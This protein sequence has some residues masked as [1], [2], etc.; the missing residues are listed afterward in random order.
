MKKLLC[1]LFV[2]SFTLS[3][4]QINP[5]SERSKLPQTGNAPTV[6]AFTVNG[7]TAAD[8]VL[9]IQP[10]SFGTVRTQPD[11]PLKYR[12]KRNSTGQIIWQKVY[13]VKS[14][15]GGVII[16]GA[17][18][19]LNTVVNESKLDFQFGELGDFTSLGSTTDE[20]GMA[21]VRLQQTH[22]GIPVYGGEWIYHLVNNEVVLGNGRVYEN[23]KTTTTANLNS[24]KAAQIGLAE[25]LSDHPKRESVYEFP[26]PQL[27][28]RV[29]EEGLATLVYRMEVRP[30][31][32]H[33]YDV[34][35]DAITGAILEKTD[36][37]CSIG[38]TAQ[39]KDLSGTT[40]TI[41]TY[42]AGGTY[43][44][45]DAS[46]DMFKS[47][48]SIPSKV[49]GGIQ[50]LDARNTSASTVY[51]ITNSS[52]SW[53]DASAVSAHYNAGLSYEYF[54]STHGR[55]SINGSG[56]TIVSVVNVT[57]DDG[58]GLDN[59]YW[60]GRWMFYGNGRN[61]FEPL[62]GGLD[63]A[64]HEL[65]HGVISNTANLEYKNQSGAINE[66]FADI[67]GVMID[68]DDWTLGEDIVKKNVYTSGAMR[69]L[70][71]PH[72]GGN[73]LG[74]RGYQPKRMSEFYTG[75]AD[76]GGVHINSGIPNHAFYLFA[77][78]V[79]KDKA[80]KV[81][82][83]ALS[84][85]LTTK[86]QF[87]DL[88]YAVER[89]ATDLYGS[90][91]LSEV[92]KAF[93]QVEIYDP[94]NN[95]SGNGDEPDDLSVNPGTQY[96]VSAD[97][98]SADENTLYRS[99]TVGEDFLA[100][101]KTVPARKASITDDGSEII[102]VS[103]S[104]ELYRITIGSSVTQTKISN[105]LWANA[106]ISKD[107]NMLAAVSTVKDSAIYVYH[108]EKEEWRE[109]RLYNPTYTEGVDAGGV[110]RAD[111]IE[112]DPSG[113]Y[114]LYDAESVIENQ[115]GSDYS[116][117]D[118]GLLHVWDLEK[119]DWSGGKIEKVFTQ[120][121]EGVSIGNASFAKNSPHIIAYDYIDVNSGQSSVVTRNLVTNASSTIYTGS[122]LGFPSYSIK[123]DQMIFDAFNTLNEE[124]VGIVD[125][126]ADKLT[127]DGSATV[128]I[129]DAKWAS[130]YATGTRA[131]LS[132]KKEITSFSFPGLS[133]SPEGKIEGTTIS[134][135][136]QAGS[137]LTEMIPTF[138]HSVNSKVF[139][140]GT[141]QISGVSKV[142]FS[143]QVTYT[144]RAQDGTTQDYQVNATQLAD[145][146]QLAK[147]HWNAYP[148]PFTERIEIQLVQPGNI[149]LTNA[150]GKVVYQR[151]L[152]EGH[153]V[154]DWSDLPSGTYFLKESSGNRRKV[155]RLV[156]L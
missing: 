36:L 56:G 103:S 32:L 8:E 124:V 156:K 109:F 152:T 11:K 153:H 107:G 149:Q 20:L 121:P 133:G 53:N 34:W 29:N 68:R 94:N 62:A 145:V 126:Q 13:P 136:L 135:T 39:A 12:Y 26:T 16:G 129:E 18:L 14:N 2:C 140:N 106:A 79:G 15:P 154:L 97:V 99:N 58:S 41:N 67:F 71:N 28:I 27:M 132:D 49:V 59:A 144:V 113:Q 66:S 31:V 105:D 111:A 7:R 128:L 139:I 72:N 44:L 45:V 75:S 93:D 25:V 141:E 92:K 114:I 96:I 78:A 100:I 89:S 54:K 134:I 120:L 60:N 104:N 70:S 146:Q 150:F 38:A 115:G 9:P 52:N 123:D 125:L 110:L 22:N 138:T 61:A 76:N 130:W 117:W 80:E 47:S 88:R 3:F 91:E 81:Y 127:R 50:T 87:L 131:L 51:H 102:F 85:Y 10:G 83:R 84:Q 73:S 86:S 119:D 40:Q 21:H 69:S 98:N 82:F 43:Y 108:F 57:E 137:N 148:N 23:L 122:K 118:V 155:L 37:L 30:D 24:A 65:T 46:R 1:F 90:T 19:S 147:N 116:Y 17:D 55:N 143:S 6:E 101:S 33:V 151:K 77:I 5:F 95:G 42:Q 35:V 4:G 64:G 112:F 142:N 63:V 74:D 48:S